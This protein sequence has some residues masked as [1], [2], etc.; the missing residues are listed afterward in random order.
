MA[1]YR[2]LIYS[3]LDRIK[4]I[5]D[6]SII[7][8]DHVIFTID[9]VRAAL[10]YQKYGEVKREVIESNYQTLCLDLEQVVNS[11]VCGEI[12]M[13][14]TK[15]I[16]SLLNIGN[17]S[18]YPLDFYKGNIAFVSRERM[19]YVG[20]NKLLQNIIYASLNPDGRVYLKSKN[21]QFL[22][23]EKI[24]IT[25]IFENAMEALELECSQICEPWD[26]IVPI[27]EDLIP[28]LTETVVKDLLGALYRPA[29]EQ[30]NMSDDLANIYSFIKRNIKSGLQK[31]IEE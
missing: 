26:R 23:L 28:V 15:S 17:T 13:R 19:K 1:T 31:Q 7:T 2:E 14:T 6:D 24:S 29:D 16:P 30:N 12:Y 20:Y 10:L 25:G 9:K 3:V 22:Y 8:E 21:P 4:A 27:E 18:I 11:E 5:S